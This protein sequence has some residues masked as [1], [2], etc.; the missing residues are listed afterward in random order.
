MRVFH[1]E[2][3]MCYPPARRPLGGL[4]LAGKGGAKG[5][6][7][8][9][10]GNLIPVRPG[11]VRNPAGI[12]GTTGKKAFLARLDARLLEPASGR[13]GTRSHAERQADAILDL[14]SGK[15]AGPKPEAWEVKQARD[16]LWSR[17]LPA[18]ALELEVS[19][20]LRISD[21]DRQAA[22]SRLDTL[23]KRAAG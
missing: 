15:A 20:E 21:E 17:L 22:H 18:L 16:L 5:K 10:N 1:M 19:G 2:H 13:K 4:R 7:V 23:I 11:E 14:C 12:N 8:G 9:R 6:G 3:P